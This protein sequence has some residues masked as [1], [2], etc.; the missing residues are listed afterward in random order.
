MGTLGINTYKGMIQG[1]NSYYY[2]WIPKVYQLFNIHVWKKETP[3]LCAYIEQ[4][5]DNYYF[6]DLQALQYRPFTILAI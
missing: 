5:K 2:M 6:K 1:S 3:P 4:V